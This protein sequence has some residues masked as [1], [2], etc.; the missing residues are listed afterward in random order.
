MDDLGYVLSDPALVGEVGRY[1]H[2]G[3]YDVVALGGVE[4]FEDFA[5]ACDAGA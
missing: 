3:D 4:L 5:D 2:G 1:F